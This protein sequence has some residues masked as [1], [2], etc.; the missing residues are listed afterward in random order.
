IAKPA[1]ETPL[2]AAQAMRLFLG[3]GL[4]PGVLQL[5]PGD[6]RIGARLVANPAIAGVVFTGSTE[7]ARSIHKTLSLRLGRDG[8]PIPLIAG[9]GGQNA[10]VVDSSA[11]PGRLVQAAV[12][13]AFDSAGQRCWALRVLC[14]QEDIAERVVPMLK[15]ALAELAVGNPDRLSTDVGPVISAD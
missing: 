12:P 10:L 7:A 14:L 6:G 4:P 11:W 15:G 3:A 8:K 13:S 5:L 1:E 2:I 9:T